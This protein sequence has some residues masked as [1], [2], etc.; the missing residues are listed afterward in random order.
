[1][2][3]LQP[4][5]L[6]SYLVPFPSL[7]PYIP[8]IPMFLFLFLSLNPFLGNLSPLGLSLKDHLRKALSNFLNYSSNYSTDSWSIQYHVFISLLEFSLSEIILPV[9]LSV[10]CLPPGTRI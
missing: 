4:T 10:Y 6:T 5:S 3:W 9:H 1:M 8:T 2:T 7:Q